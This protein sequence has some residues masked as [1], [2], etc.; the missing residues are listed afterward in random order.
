MGLRK[1]S[2]VLYS[3]DQQSL[4]YLFN[5]QNGNIKIDFTYYAEPWK[6]CPQF[7]EFSFLNC[8][9]KWVLR[10]IKSFFIPSLFS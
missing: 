1:S 8:T 2:I 6:Y 9:W 3:I 5:T 10:A 4:G 7:E